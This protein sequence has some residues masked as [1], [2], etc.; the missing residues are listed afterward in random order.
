MQTL[1]KGEWSESYCVLRVIADGKLQLCDSDL[2]LTGEQIKING[3]TI[4]PAV[5][6]KIVGDIVELIANGASKE[7]SKHDIAKLAEKTLHLI[8]ST[9]EKTFSLPEIAE[10]FGTQSLKAKASNKIDTIIN[11]FD[12]I[13]NANEEL[14]FSI[15]SFLAGSPTLVN[16]SRATN[17]TYNVA[18]TK[19]EQKY[20]DLKAKTLLRSL[21]VDNIN[22]IFDKM[23]SDIY[24]NNLMR[25]DLKMP[26]ILAEFLKIYYSSKT[27]LVSEITA[28]LQ[29]L[30]PLQ[31][32]DKS[33]YKSKI[34][35]Y[36]FYSAVGMF[37]NKNWQ[38]IADI[39]GGCMI[40]EESGEVKTFYIFRKA[41]L[42]FF[43]EY[44][45]NRCF[46]DTPST[47]RHGFARLYEENNNVKLKLNLQIR[48]TK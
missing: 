41:F 39:D 26:E 46:L 9:H 24:Q 3:G 4:S 36:L 25:I 45:F 20:K 11:I 6:Y 17:F 37:P 48:I 15:K 38:G 21:N 12:D 43:R 44:L 14:G 47:T 28:Q 29:E 19:I 32:I 40:V 5:H 2:L 1:N 23:D 42:Q 34:I 35:D 33:L 16:A 13:T 8:K 30:N 10:L 22:V 7:V 18:L 31:L 27:K